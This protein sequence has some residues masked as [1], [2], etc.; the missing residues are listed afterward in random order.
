MLKV[1]RCLLP[2]IPMVLLVLLVAPVNLP[3]FDQPH[4][5]GHNTCELLPTLNAILQWLGL[6]RICDI[7]GSPVHL[8]H[9]N[10]F[11]SNQDLFI[12]G[13]GLSLEVIRKYDSHD[14]YDGPF[15]HGW[16]FN[17][18]TKLT[19]VTDEVD[20]W[21]IIR[22][23]DG[24]R[25]I[26]LKN[27]D[28]TY[29]SPQGRQD[30]LIR[31]ADG[32]FAWHESGCGTCGGN[33]YDFDASGYLKQIKDAY[34]NKMTFDYDMDGNLIE[35]TDASGRQ[36]N[37]T[38]GANNKVSTVTDPAKRIFKYGYDTNQN[39]I[40]YTD[41]MGYITRYAYDSGHRL[42]GIT[43][44]RGNAATT[45]TYDDQG[46]VKTYSES[47]EVWTYS[48]EPENNRTYK[49][50]TEGNRWTYGYNDTGQKVYEGPPW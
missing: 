7:F 26:F 45:V 19:E 13:R 2:L 14:L 12:P 49:D 5:S 10:Y 27:P 23:A 48:Y 16:K 4:D 8:V 42:I 34:D 15:G 17:Y 44:P 37:I 22:R 20:V 28:G 50:D 11:Y 3:A 21:V 9:G 43:D 32:T 18:D 38:Y 29:A 47:E 40:T 33:S 6:P 36:L 25:L 31:N 41:P 30:A 24:V 39:L 35:V 1:K 46:R